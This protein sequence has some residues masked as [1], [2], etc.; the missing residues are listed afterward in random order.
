MI[1]VL[2]LKKTFCNTLIIN[3][4]SFE[5]KNGSGLFL[6]GKNG[7]GKTTLLNMICGFDNDYDGKIIVDNT[8]MKNHIQ[9]SKRNIS[10]V[11]QDATLWNFMNVESNIKYALTKESFNLYDELIDR[12]E[13]NKIL[14]KYP[15]EISG[16]QAKRVAIARALL[17]NK[18]NILLDEPLANI[19]IESKKIIIDFIKEFYVNNN[20]Y[21]ILYITHDIAEIKE[22]KFDVIRL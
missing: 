20:K 8:L 15:E 17:S 12:M 4:L 21:S 14:K 11:M 19:D 10:L 16:G 5:L 13:L 9:P 6:V 1:K 22:F 3:N 7:A 2:N 18:N